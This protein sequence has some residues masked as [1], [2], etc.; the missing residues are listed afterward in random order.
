MV[1]ALGGPA[2][3]C[4]R[5]LAVD[6]DAETVPTPPTIGGVALETVVARLEQVISAAMERAKVPGLAVALIAG[7]EVVWVKGFGVRSL[8]T[9]EPVT[10]QTVF[11]GASLSKN[12][13]A[14]AALKM[15]ET[16]AL[17][18]DR[19]LADYVPEPYLPGSRIQEI[20]LRMVLSHTSGFSALSAD[21]GLVVYRPGTVFAYSNDAFRYLQWVMEHVSGKPLAEYMEENL[22]SPLGLAS[23]SFVWTADYEDRVARGHNDG[24]EVPLYRPSQANAAYGVYTTAPDFARFITEII[25]AGEGD[26]A[27]LSRATV[28]EMLRPQVTVVEG[29]LSWGLGWGL[30]HGETGRS[31]WQWGWKDGYRN[32]VLADPDRGLGVVIL[33]N[34][35]EG[36][37]ICEEIVV[38]AIGGEHPAFSDYLNRWIGP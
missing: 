10:P 5:P 14:Y 7:G 28:E 1:L 27:R 33:T 9:R 23:T 24:S 16:G 34:G 4:H 37:R 35:D 18:L 38:T 29:S 20:T 15:V 17:E 12:L 13:V 31:F 36:L 21:R 22:F 8:Q 6:P 25:G 11:R 2:A 32:F 19:P 3:G 30:E 26:A